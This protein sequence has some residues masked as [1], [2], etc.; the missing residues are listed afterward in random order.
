[1]QENRKK[2]FK[3]IKEMYKL[4]TRVVKDYKNYEKVIDINEFNKNY[5]EL[6]QIHNFTESLDAKNEYFVIK[7]IKN[8]FKIPEIPKI[9]LNLVEII[10]NNVVLKENVVLSEEEKLAFDNFQ[11]EVNKINEINKLILK[12]NE[13]YEYL[14]ELN[15]RI[16]DFEEKIEIVYAKGVFI[17]KQSENEIEDSVR[18]HVF[19]ANLNID[20]DTN[21]NI[22]YLKLDRQTKCNIVYNF[23][24]SI[25][26]YKVKSKEDLY[27]V[28]QNVTQK[29]EVEEPI[30]F[31][32]LYDE[33]L[34]AVTYEYEILDETSSLVNN[35]SYIID[36][37]HIIIRKKQPTIWLDDLNTIDEKIES[38]VEINN[39]FVDLILET[40]TNNIDKLLKSPEEEYKKVL[41]PLESNEEQYR[42]V[43]QTKTSNLVLV[44]GPPGTGKSHTIANLISNYVANGKKVLVTSEKSKAL[45]VIREKLPEEIRKLSIAI[46]NDSKNDNDL[47]DSIQTVLEK[48]KDKD[49]LEQY[50]IEINNLEIKL[51][52]ITNKKEENEKA[53]LNILINSTKD[54]RD[55][56]LRILNINMQSY[57]LLNIAKYLKENETLDIIRD[58]N[59]GYSYNNLIFNSSLFTSI[60]QNVDKFRKCYELINNQVIVSSKILEVEDFEE[61]INTINENEIFLIDNLAILGG[62]KEDVIVNVNIQQ[63][64]ELLDRV[65][66]LEKVFNKEY[67]KK[68]CDYTPRLKNIQKIIDELCSEKENFEKIETESLDSIIEYDNNKMNVLYD[69]LLKVYDKIKEDGK[70]NIFEKVQIIKELDSISDIKIN[71][72]ELKDKNVDLNNIKKVLDRVSYD[73]KVQKIKKNIESILVKSSIF[74]NV[75][76]CEFSRS[77][78]YLINILTTFVRYK[79]DT[80]NIKNTLISAFESNNSVKGLVESENYEKLL[81]CVTVISK[82]IE[83]LKYKLDYFRKIDELKKE[84]S[85]NLE[86]YKEVIC[87]LEHLNLVE[88]IENKKVLDETIFCFELLNSLKLSYKNEFVNYPLFISDLI[89]KYSKEELEVIINNFG[90]IFAYYRLKKLFLSEESKNNNLNDLLIKKR[91]YQV[92][93]KNTI[94]KLIETKSWYNQINSMDNVICR[95]L[96]KWVSLKTKLGKGTGKR[97]NLIRKEMQ[98][99][100]EIAKNAIPVWIM[101][102]DKVIEQYPFSEVPQF[103]VLIMDESSQSSILS[104]TALMRG[105][106]LI[107][108]GDDKQISPVSVG[109]VVDELKDLQDKYLKDTCL[110]I[111]FDMETSIYDLA[112]NVCGS[113]KVVLK[114]HFRCLPEIIEFSNVNFYLSQINCLKVR[115]NKNTI[116]D[117]IKSYYIENATVQS[118]GNSMANKKE[119]EKVISLLKEF[120]NSD[121]YKNKTIGII[122]LQNSSAQI[123]LI[124]NEI[125]KNFSAE[126][127]KNTNLKV[128]TTY[129]FQGDERDVIIL[130]MIVSKYTEDGEENRVVALTKKEYARSFNVAAS[131]AKEQSILVYSILPEE[132]SSECYRYKLINYYNNYMINKDIRKENEFNTEF[133]KD[134]FDLLSENKIE[135]KHNFKIGKYSVDFEYDGKNGNKVAIEC[136][137]DRDF[138]ENEYI[139]QIEKQNILERCGW[140]FIRVRASSFYYDRE[141]TIAQ[142]KEKLNS[143]D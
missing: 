111:G 83:N 108:V 53:I 25:N 84:V 78:D 93:E 31:K 121:E 137:G 20:V 1:M 60:R 24:T 59:Y 112:Q 136:D 28:E 48:Y 3:Y 96:S 29:Y 109:I 9:L 41:F 143:I 6:S 77:V 87:S 142:I 124:N 57:M 45:E 91:E 76:D 85:E 36:K 114:E 92:E 126:Y 4:K 34:N 71:G 82:Y 38:G 138:M 30:D 32:K 113:K 106:K 88:F 140:N 51:G 99:N 22:I 130:S 23:L 72:V 65:V 56:V 61:Y 10:E 123:K 101:P 119:V 8:Y 95:A 74:E 39:N 17:Y 127:I 125:W 21:Q 94:I 18:R 55:E 67:I 7:Y 27:E 62:L 66:C 54:Y 11:V 35:K 133:E 118:S 135:V 117:P 52:E 19:E 89:K 122:V 42:V 50:L 69:A 46:L 40:D 110:G 128:G 116:K 2:L 43:N 98:E 5:L 141:S 139:L 63:I 58:E 107:I 102:V 120:E 12:Y 80:E 75:N 134:L 129:D 64:K 15:K 26:N 131:R 132:L 97:A 79:E 16:N 33:Y 103:D 47:L 105:K 13:L 68:N 37:S 14:Y 44:Q 49:Y 81:S 90:V 73:I 70:I 86:A 115:S 100:M 104:L